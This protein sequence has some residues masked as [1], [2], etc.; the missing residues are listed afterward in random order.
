[1]AINGS[2]VLLSINTGTDESP[3][4][5]VIPCQITADYSLSVSTRDTSCKESADD[6]NAPGSRSRTMSVETLPTAWPLLA[7]TPS[8]AE[9]ILRSKAETGEQID[10]RIVVS[11]RSARGVHRHHHLAVGRR[12]P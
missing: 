2:S 4:Y 11:S 5:T 9:Q 3:T 8:G 1:M 7:D 12:S 6:T 10:G